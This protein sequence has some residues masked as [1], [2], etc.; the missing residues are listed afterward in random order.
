MSPRSSHEESLTEEHDRTE[1]AAKQR[2]RDDH[3]RTF[4]IYDACREPLVLFSQI[5][6][7]AAECHEARVNTL[8]ISVYF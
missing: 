8:F 1:S 5:E 3:S 7:Q 4:F 6:E 2:A